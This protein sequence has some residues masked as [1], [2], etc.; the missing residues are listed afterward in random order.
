[1]M[2]ITHP[3]ATD[4]H[5]ASTTVIP[6]AEVLA[7]IGVG[8]AHRVIHPVIH[9]VMLDMAIADTGMM[10]SDICRTGLMMVGEERG[11]SRVCLVPEMLA[12]QPLILRPR[13]L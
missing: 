4:P 6:I 12:W 3:V 1:M 5:P 11:V 7:T 9:P 10:D 8:K 13:M 2:A